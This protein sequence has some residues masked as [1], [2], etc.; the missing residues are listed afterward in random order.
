MEIKL[1]IIIREI[2]NIEVFETVESAELKLEPID[3]LNG[4]FVGYD[5]EGR[6]LS[7][8]IREKERSSLFGLTKVPV[9]VTKIFCY[10][11]EPTHQKELYESLIRFLKKIDEPLSLEETLKNLINK[12]I[13]RG[14]YT[15]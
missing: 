5:A 13:D 4:E 6:L 9:E 14:G 8:E 7:L 11:K 2:E 3:V 10:E 15:I 1:P 12:V